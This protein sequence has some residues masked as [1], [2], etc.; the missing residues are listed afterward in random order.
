MDPRETYILIGASLR[1]C[2]EEESCSFTRQPPNPPLSHEEPIN[3]LGDKRG[4][5]CRSPIAL[6]FKSLGLE[7]RAREQALY[8]KWGGKEGPPAGHREAA[9]K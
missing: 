9:W 5:T 8:G 1:R 6:S 3:N 2:A 7:E 4:G